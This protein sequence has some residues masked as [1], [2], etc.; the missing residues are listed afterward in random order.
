M[1]EL[2]KVRDEQTLLELASKHSMH[3]TM[4]AQWKYQ[5]LEGMAATFS[6]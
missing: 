5:T 2:E 6:R 3:Q 1:I 4:I